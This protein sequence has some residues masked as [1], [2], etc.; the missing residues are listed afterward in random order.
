MSDQADVKSIDTLAFIKAALASY[1]HES[2]QA[3]G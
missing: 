2:G 1:A 3:L